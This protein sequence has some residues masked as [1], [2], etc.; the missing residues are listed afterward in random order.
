MKKVIKKIV[1]PFDSFDEFDEEVIEEV[2]IE[3]ED[4][5]VPASVKDEATH[6]I[7]EDEQAPT[8]APAEPTP[9]MVEPITI[10]AEEKPA[11]KKGGRK[12]KVEDA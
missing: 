1:E 8:P 3:E 6:V 12:K 2:I 7:E 9:V 5:V 10:L 4:K 11:A